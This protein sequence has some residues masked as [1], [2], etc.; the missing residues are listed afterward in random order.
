MQFVGRNSHDG[1]IFRMHVTNSK[2]ILSTAEV[3][4]VELTP[5]SYCWENWARILGERVKCEAVG[6]EEED[7]GDERS[8]NGCQWPR[9]D[10]I[11]GKHS[12][13]NARAIESKGSGSTVLEG[14][15]KTKQ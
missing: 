4:M 10:K 13:T 12:V 1:T 15:S 14:T 2:K 9:N 6:I 11:E 7:I 5:Q 8:S 3:V